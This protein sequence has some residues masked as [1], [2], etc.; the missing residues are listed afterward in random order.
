MEVLEAEQRVDVQARDRRRVLLGDGLDVH[1]A[2]GR[3]H[4]QRGL[5][6][7]VEDEG[8]VVLG[9]DVARLLDPQLAHGEAAD[10]HAEDRLGVGPRLVA[11]LRHLDAAGL[12]A[13][14]DLHLCLDDD[15][16][17]DP[18]GHVERLVDGR[19][20]PAA[21]HRD[22][23]AGEELLALIFEKVHESARL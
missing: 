9:G 17:A 19:G 7:A 14:A 4:R 18:V 22:P 15:R 3:Q 23:V 6:R 10:V 1:P 11:V 12:A 21:G 8:G 13:P 20:V 5:G 2:L 16:I